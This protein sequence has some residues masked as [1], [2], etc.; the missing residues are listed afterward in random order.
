MHKLAICL[1][2]AALGCGDDTQPVGPDAASPDSPTIDAPMPDAAPPD[3]YTYDFSCISTPWPTTAPDPVGVGGGI[4]EQPGAIAV[5][6]MTVDLLKLTDDSVLGT[7]T[8][9]STGRFNLSVATGGVAPVAYFKYTKTGFIDGYAFGPSAIFRNAQNGDLPTLTPADMTMYAQASG[10]S[11][12]DANKSV[13]AVE[14]HDCNGFFAPGASIT[15][16]PPGGTIVYFGANHAPDTSLTQTTTDGKVAIFNAT[17]STNY[18]VTIV[19][20]GHTYRTWPIK[21]FAGTF[22]WS[23]RLP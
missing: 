12:L 20:Q 14:V 3:A 22:S 17:P 4:H 15:L 18:D 19:N 10:V 11:S 16:N 6:N 5:V 8:T 21:A 2:V 7:T 13:V 9:S 1:L 23:V